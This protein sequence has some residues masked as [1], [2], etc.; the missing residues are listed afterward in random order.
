M[1]TFTGR[2]ERYPARA[3]F[4]GFALLIGCGAALLRLPIS[5]VEGQ[6]GLSTIDALFMATSA[7][8]V[9]GL[10]V[11]S[12]GHHLSLFGQGVLLT[13]IQL[14]GIGIMTM[15][16]FVVLG[17]GGRQTLRHRALVAQSFG[18]ASGDIRRLLWRILRLVIACELAGFV[19]L[20]VANL[21][22]GE[23]S[24]IESVGH[25]LFHSISAF[26]NAGFALYDDNLVRFQNNAWVSL[27]IMALIV[28][29][30][31]GFPVIID[32]QRAI[33]KPRRDAWEALSLHSKIM[34][35]GTA[36]LIAVGFVLF[37]LLEWNGVL[38]G[39]PLG[40]R[41]LLAGFQVVTPRT[42]GFQTVDLARLREATLFGMVVLMLIGGGPGSTAGGFKVSTFMILICHAWSRFRGHNR[43]RLFR[44]SLAIDTIATAMATTLVFAAVF[45]G[46]FTLLLMVEPATSGSFL[47]ALFE[48]ASALG[49][50]GLSVDVNAPVDSGA[51]SISSF[52][53]SLNSA[54]KYIIIALM[55][56]GR[57]GPISVFLAVA[58]A[59]QRDRIEYPPEE[60]LI[61]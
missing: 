46:S 15:T 3:T 16:T 13:L 51:E 48:T 27:T 5:T 4:V 38:N 20:A 47:N 7:A 6:P 23:L 30:G 42:A 25:A 40:R 50:V 59:E 56:L 61:G 43:V 18:T 12:V 33:G 35:V 45:G 32:L 19:L 2:L 55:F 52:T 26:C 37:L 41:F 49:T 14:G 39:M 1:A 44:R 57:L 54:G 58:R 28:V 17:F 9:T 34:L 22:L 24:F 36:G 29:G 60:V 31:I 10:S 11:V 21:W 53:A 8:C